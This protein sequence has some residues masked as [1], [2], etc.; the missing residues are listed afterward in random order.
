MQVLSEQVRQVHHEALTLGRSA[1]EAFDAATEACR[2]ANPAIG[3][4]AAERLVVG[5]L[6]DAGAR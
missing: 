4:V 6:R 3:R 5:L 1:I 2:R